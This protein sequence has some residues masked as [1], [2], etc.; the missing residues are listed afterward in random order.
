L[1]IDALFEVCEE[2]GGSRTVTKALV[3]HFEDF[4]AAAAD[5]GIQVYKE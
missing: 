1:V 4:I 2:L 3:K 5:G